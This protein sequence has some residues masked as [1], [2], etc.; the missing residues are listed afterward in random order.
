L[1]PIIIYA[2]LLVA[3]TFGANYEMSHG[4][5]WI[6]WLLMAILIAQCLHCK[7]KINL[8]SIINF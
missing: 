6:V 5:T 1:S 8:F 7:K 3:R 2:V 4:E